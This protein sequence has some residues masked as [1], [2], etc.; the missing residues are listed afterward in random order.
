MTSI[1]AGLL[2]RV[3]VKTAINVARQ[4]KYLLSVRNITSS[5]C[6]F[7]FPADNPQRALRRHC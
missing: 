1:F 3:G 6:I 7:S 2:L 5:F 4:A